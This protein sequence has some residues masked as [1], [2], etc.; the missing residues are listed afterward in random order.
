MVAKDFLTWNTQTGGLLT[1]CVLLPSDAADAILPDQVAG[2][3]FRRV[4]ASAIDSAN[5]PATRQAIGR[6]FTK[7]LPMQPSRKGS[8]QSVFQCS[9]SHRR[10]E[11]KTRSRE[12]SSKGVCLYSQSRG[13]RN[14]QIS[15]LRGPFARHP[16]VW[17]MTPD[18]RT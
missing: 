3:G 8:L 15:K 7:C 9:Q 5:L 17:A 13:R 18:A 10:M 16:P 11:I 4:P 14:R 12:G 1:A 6:S 2:R